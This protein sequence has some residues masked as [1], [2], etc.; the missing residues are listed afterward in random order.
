MSRF[1]P[2]LDTVELT[3][4][5]TRWLRTFGAGRNQAGLRYGQWLCN[6][7]LKTGETFP[8]L[9][10]VESASEAYSIAYAELLE[11]ILS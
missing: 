4:T 7:C 3:R 6:F 11:E 10:Y 8:E 9:F 5:Y 2:H 1:V